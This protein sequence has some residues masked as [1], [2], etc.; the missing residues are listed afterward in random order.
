[1]RT[2]GLVVLALAIGSGL[3]RAADQWTA[4]TSTDPMT[5][6]ARIVLDGTSAEGNGTLL[7]GCNGGTS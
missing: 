5:D 4:Q 2:A 6:K 3:G 7:V 1:M